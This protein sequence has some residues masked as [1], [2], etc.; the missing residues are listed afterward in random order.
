[1]PVTHFPDPRRADEDGLLAVGGD[2]HPDSLLLAYRSGIFPWPMTP[3]VNWP[4]DEEFPL[5]WFSPAERAV[6]EFDHLHIPRSLE[7]ARRQSKLRFSV[8]EAFPKVIELCGSVRRGR[9]EEQLASQGTWITSEMRD[10]YLEFHR[11]GHAHSFE[12]WNEKC[13][14]VG[15]LYGVDADGAFAGES[16]FHLESNASKLVLLFIADHFKAR[17]LDWMDIQVMTPHMEALGARLISR[18]DFLKRLAETRRR[19]LRLFG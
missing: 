13:E 11:L 3:P 2:L 5:T 4:K 9:A 8:D 16:M 6:L 1:M 12:A 7:R 17:G 14:L 15:G 19:G 10:A 18:N